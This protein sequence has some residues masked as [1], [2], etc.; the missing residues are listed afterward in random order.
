MLKKV[1][2]RLAQW[3]IEKQNNKNHWLSPLDFAV[4]INELLNEVDKEIELK[5][6]DKVVKMWKLLKQEHI[7][8]VYK[9]SIENKRVEMVLKIENDVV[10]TLTEDGAPLDIAFISKGLK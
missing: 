6:K 7:S 5:G 2:E 10:K 9:W 8:N 3:Y 1:E 4:D